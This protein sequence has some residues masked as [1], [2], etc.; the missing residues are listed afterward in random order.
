MEQEIVFDPVWASI[1]QRCKNEEFVTLG[2]VTISTQGLS[3]SRFK[4]IDNETDDYEYPFLN[5]GQVYTYN[6]SRKTARLLYELCEGDFL[7]ERN[8]PACLHEHHEVDLVFATEL[9]ARKNHVMRRA[10]VP[11]AHLALL[12]GLQPVSFGC[13]REGG[14]VVDVLGE[15]ARLVGDGVLRDREEAHLLKEQIWKPLEVGFGKQNNLFP[16]GFADCY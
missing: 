13:L 6:G 4:L 9:D 1:I 16:N 14:R 11:L 8:F 10:K 15:E 3:G 2:D 7:L 12:Q 5:K